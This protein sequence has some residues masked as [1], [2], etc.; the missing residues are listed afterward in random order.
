MVQHLS[1]PRPL[2]DPRPGVTFAVDLVEP[3]DKP[4]PVS[5]A[6]GLVAQRLART[7]IHADLGAEELI[8]WRDVDRVGPARDSNAFA[9]AVHLAFSH[10]RP[11][12]ISPDVMWLT[13]AQG[14]AIH[15][16]HHAEELREQLV[17]FAGKRSLQIDRGRLASE[18]GRGEWAEAIGEF[19]ALVESTSNS[20]ALPDMVAR[21]STTTPAARVA[22]QVCLL[23]ALSS[24][25]DLQM[26]CICGFPQITVLGT[27]ADWQDIRARVDRL[28]GIGLGW[29][30]EHLI[31]ICDGFIAA[32]AGTPELAHWQGMYKPEE[33]YAVEAITGWFGKLFPYLLDRDD[34]PNRRNPMLTGGDEE[35]HHHELPHG[36][37][38][39][40]IQVV[41]PRGEA[42]VELLAGMF[43][44]RQD[45]TTL[46]LEPT[47]GW[48]VAEPETMDAALQAIAR[49]SEHEFVACEQKTDWRDRGIGCADMMK[50][51]DTYEQVRLFARDPDRRI[52]FD[53][54]YPFDLQLNPE[55][56]DD[57]LFFFVVGRGPDGRELRVLH[58]RWGDRLRSEVFIYTDKGAGK[59]VLA[60]NFAEFVRRCVAEG[61]FWLHEDALGSARS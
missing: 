59:R 28:A 7:I 27:V 47:I 22:S 61:P 50:F 43:G 48:L 25:Y 20:D 31:P 55:D 35:I 57:R 17:P 10:H 33:R 51:F 4:T 24:Y 21:F 41:E 52:E 58:Q 39:A 11:L 44:V 6:R 12:I 2:D 36:L 56:Y 49:S 40:T 53:G 46:A 34:V 32:A 16:H 29:W 14:I 9:D 37:S 19:A 38:R 18:L 60:N 42:R 54:P 13:I 26:R 8:T 1:G 23:D 15:V 45:P 30:S 3:T 5:E